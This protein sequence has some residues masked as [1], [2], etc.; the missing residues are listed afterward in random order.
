MNETQKAVDDFRNVAKGFRAVVALSDR[1]EVIGNL[2]QAENEFKASIARLRKE[3][4]AQLLANAEAKERHEKESQTMADQH[5]AEK[6][7]LEDE[8]RE[9]AD[10]ILTKATAKAGALEARAAELVADADA[11]VAAL[12]SKR[13]ELA[14]T[15]AALTTEAQDIEKRIAQARAQA[16][17][18]LGS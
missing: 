3:H 10:T 6:A 14:E 18:L 8:A 2:E 17:K 11:K 9:K 16:A 5:K 15:V 4:E 1:L 13:A 12:E 7:R